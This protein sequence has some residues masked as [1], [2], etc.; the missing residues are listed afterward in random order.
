M[1]DEVRALELLTAD[2]QAGARGR[3]WES[4]G[5]VEGYG[6][7]QADGDGFEV[8]DPDEVLRTR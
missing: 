8:I 2:G 1:N 3:A 4:S 5:G 7:G 6:D